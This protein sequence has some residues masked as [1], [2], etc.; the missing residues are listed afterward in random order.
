MK[1]LNKNI[2]KGILSV[3]I[4][5]QNDL[6]YLSHIIDVGDLVSGKTK[7]KIKI[8]DGTDRNTKTVTKKV[9][10]KLQVEK[11]EFHK[12]SDKLRV[13]GK[14]VDGPEDISRGTYHTFT[15]EPTVEIKIEKEKW[16]KFQ[17]DK[18]D[19][20]AKE[21]DTNI[22]I[23]LLDR[24]KALFA[25]LKNYGFDIIGKITGN[26]QKKDSP[27]KIKSSF[28]QEV[29]SHLKDYDTKQNLSKIILASPAFWKD[30]LT[31]ALEND[32]LKSKIIHSACNS[33]DVDGINEVLRRPEII[34]A[35]KNDRVI[36]EINA[37]EKLL[38]EINKDANAVYG[39]KETK[40]ALEA[41]AVKT[42]LVN[43]SFMHDAREKGT[44]EVI[45]NML[46]KVDSMKGE[47]II[48]SAEHDGGKKLN[49][50]GGIGALLRYKL[51]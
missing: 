1:I 11:I 49:G 30:Y 2:K 42:L 9:F 34:T 21:K 24:D 17:L 10:L 32:P 50:L 3:R 4:Q 15:L 28:Y 37:V 22:L 13:S 23:C 40:L 16:L 39:L 14:I 44:Y 6:W 51:S 25:Q 19:D 43:D 8:G 27:E 31:Q 26:V 29:I 33:V 41:G 7:R 20:S 48:I 12:Y 18:L 47:I 46:K 38:Q 35:L 45:D 36:R 5:N